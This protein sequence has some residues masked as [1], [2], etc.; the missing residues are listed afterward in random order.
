[1]KNIIKVFIALAL[2][3]A[4]LTSCSFINSGNENQGGDQGG[5]QGGDQGGNQGGD[6]GGNQGGDQGGNQ[7]GDQGGNQGG[8]QG[9]NQGGDQG[10]NQGGNEDEKGE[11]DGWLAGDTIYYRGDATAPT[12]AIKMR[13]INETDFMLSFETDRE[14]KL[15]ILGEYDHELSRL[16]YS[17]LETLYTGDEYNTIYTICTDGSSVA[18]A[19]QSLVARDAAIKYLFDNIDDIDLTHAGLVTHEE[20]NINSYVDAERQKELDKAF[21]EAGKTLSSEAIAELRTLYGLYDRNIYLW[22]ASLYDPDLGAFYYSGSA[23]DTLGFLP[24]L[25]STAQALIFMVDSGMLTEHG[26]KYRYALPDDIKNAILDWTKG[27]QSSENGYFYH[28]QW[29]DSVTNNRLG[30]DLSWAKRIISGLGAKPYWNTPDGVRGELGKPGSTA[31]A[32]AILT[33][34]LNTSVATAVSKV[35]PTAAPAYLSSVDAFVTHLEKD[36][37]WET[38]SY[39]AGNSI[40]S[41]LGQIMA[42][43]DAYEEALINF[44]NGK[45]KSNGLWENEISYDSINGLMKISGIYTSLEQLIPNADK[46]MESAIKVLKF[47]TAPTHVC[48]VYNP[49]EAIANILITIEKGQGVAAA[50]ELRAQFREEAASLIK[51]TYD[52]LSIFEKND[53]GFSY[54][55]KYSAAR[56]QGV[57]VCVDKMAESDV[58]ATNICTNSI[59]NAM[60]DV[61]GVEQV[62]RYYSADFARFSDILIE[63]GSILKDKVLEAEEITFDE[64]DPALGEESGGVVTYPSDYTENIVGD[65]DSLDAET[66]KWFESS[67]VQNPDPNSVYGD[68]VLY[69]KSNIDVGATKPLADKPSSTVFN[70]ANAGI[71][72][73]A[74]CYVY[75]AD[76]YFV[77]KS[78]D[79]YE[80]G[81]KNSSDAATSDPMLQL[82]FKTESLPCAQLNF[83]V[84]T[85]KEK[86]YIKIGESYAGMDGKNNGVAGGI[87]M[88]EWV[89][90]RIEYYKDYEVK[91]DGSTGAYQPKMKIFVN[92]TY[93]GECD[94]TITG[95]D[96]TGA[97]N[98]YDRKIDRVAISYYRFLSSETYF[99][100]V[101]V[102]NCRKEYVKEI[103]TNAVVD[104]ALPNEEMREVADFEDG[105]LNT[106]NVANKIRVLHFGTN[107]YVNATEGQTFNPKISYSI[108]ADPKDS[109]NNVLKVIANSDKQNVYSDK[110]SRTE[111]NMYNAAANGTDYTF[112]GDFY[113]DKAISVDTLVTQLA[114][115]DTKD[116]QLYVIGI[117]AQSGGLISLE[118]QNGTKTA[119]ASDIARNDWFNLKVVFHRGGTAE[120][121]SAD[122]YLNGEKVYT[123]NTYKATAVS[124]SDPTAKVAII[125]QKSNNSTLYLDNLSLVRSGEIVEATESED[126]VADFEEGYNTKY[127]HSF[128]Y[129]GSTELAVTDI[130]DV[131]M[132]NLYTK[133]SLH[134]DPVD[135]ANTCLRA[136]NKNGGSKAGYTKVDISND[137]P[138]GNCYTFET[139]MYLETY[140]ANY[141]LTQLQFIDTNGDVAFNAYTS[142]DKTSGNFKMATTG[143]GTFPAK[144]TSLLDSSLAV[145]PKTWFTLRIEFYNAGANA[146]TSNTYMKIYIKY[147]PA[148]EEGETP[149]EVEALAYDGPAYAALGAEIDHVKL[150]HVKTAKSSAV[151]FDDISLTRTNKVYTSGK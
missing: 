126:K 9:G 7:G 139:R 22:L 66:Y 83:N 105:L 37:N 96:K 31:A 77:S 60:F 17:M 87:P 85:E 58:N 112:S 98:Y 25:E 108:V 42:K 26:D 123:D 32:A 1:M 143:D 111:I 109:T 76:M 3:I 97:T 125:H 48:T 141:N 69:A 140:S 151:L 29:G 103:N 135:E 132:S 115:L 75:D 2:T 144:G 84:Y 24:D 73:L 53:G 86:N 63:L 8:D 40:E 113:Y 72:S 38:N 102:E 131:L 128:S 148:V 94:A 92:G 61:F 65:F 23:R 55:P 19:Y 136:V 34:R 99:N 121:T 54:Y 15:L 59:I 6:Q 67:V 116:N 12:E 4:M 81:K 147:T 138:A 18:I 13:F 43:G 91:E 80:Y 146:T 104:P 137:D 28:P 117:N 100:N 78:A 39:A 120:T 21:A 56:S 46:A 101:L 57:V 71:D 79:G 90:I 74:N 47:T 64:Y 62:E 10:G 27:L 30:R 145:K 50:D 89:N 149:V 106:S 124:A 142:V 41:D 68:L 134:Q 133:Y 5:S 107:K 20:F 45:Q 150:I 88:D 44:L 122:I 51:I 110:P 33:T 130:D 93:W 70:I 118:S 49:W 119:I 35:V 11:F 14:G 16:A 82:T 127:V 36:Y 114:F 52:K 129:N 95:A